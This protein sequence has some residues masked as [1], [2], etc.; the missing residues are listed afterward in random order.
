MYKG[1]RKV[2]FCKTTD[3]G[4]TSFAATIHEAQNAESRGVFI[5]KVENSCPRS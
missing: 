4:A 2:C 3:E 5:Y 1:N